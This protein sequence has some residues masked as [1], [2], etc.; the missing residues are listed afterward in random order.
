MS[1]LAFL[2]AITYISPLLLIVGIF[3]G[4]I[5]FTSID[6]V[7]KMVLL[8]FLFSLSI[9]LSSRVLGAYNDY[10]LIL[11]PLL[12]FLEL[13]VF[14]ILYWKYLF[15]ERSMMF[16]GGIVIGLS[17]IVWEIWSIRSI[18]TTQFQSYSKAVSSL[19]I[20][21]LSVK[22]ILQELKKEEELD[23]NRLKLNNIILLF[24]SINLVIFLPLNFLINEQSILKFYF[25]MANLALTLLFYALLIHSVW[26]NGKTAQ[27]LPSGL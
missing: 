15:K 25:W 20:I 2:E 14:S 21:V 10:N 24:F 11:I 18:H 4:C 26:K 17:F 13:L 12:G 9:D 6:G 1:F 27:Q 22:Y 7:H 23:K 3:I 5:R 8:Y 19:V 16:F